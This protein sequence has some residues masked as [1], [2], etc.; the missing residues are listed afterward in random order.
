MA[1][2]KKQHYVPKLY[3]KLFANSDKKFAVYNISKKEIISP[4]PYKDQCYKNYY[5][6]PND[7]WEN[8]LSAMEVEWSNT[9]N[10]VINKKPLTESIIISLKRFALYQRQRTL[11]EEN[12]SKQIRKELLIEQ[13]K[14]ICAE[15]GWEFDATAELI[16]EQKANDSVAPAENLQFADQFIDSIEDLCVTII[17]YKS[18]YRLISSDVPVVSINP[19]HQPTIGYGCMGLIM[20][21]PISPHQLIV[22]YDGKMYPKYKGKQYVELCN[23][24]E[25]INLNALQLISAEKILFTK[26]PDDFI[27][28]KGEH[29]KIRNQNRS[30]NAIQA[31]GPNNQRLIAFS[32]RKT[33][34]LHDFTFGKI[35]HDFSS[36]PFSCRDAIPRTW[37][38]GWEDKLS[39]NIKFLPE[40]AKEHSGIAKT[41]K[42]STRDLRRELEKMYKATMKY[43]SE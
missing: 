7:V 40:I 42:L 39:N 12:F 36:I 24:N 19:F 18:K 26:E 15:K 37:E 35:R 29:W 41:L 23:D 8:R 10:H 33:I 11:A 32:P 4:V 14:Q 6:G 3:M 20:L 16:C 28:L 2:K 13:A 17:N 27:T 30:S 38:K 22:I 21:Y 5:Y 25:V 9:F 31:L 43:W 1:E 34:F